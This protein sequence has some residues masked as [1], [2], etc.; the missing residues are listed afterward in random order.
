MAPGD[1]ILIPDA[2]YPAVRDLAANFLAPHGIDCRSHDPR[3]GASIAERI[4]QR[5]RLVWVESPGCTTMQLQGVA[6]TARAAHTEGAPVGCDNTPATPAA[7]QA[8]PP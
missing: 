4:E 5:T 3:L 7:V 2:V 8:A 6:A 1:P